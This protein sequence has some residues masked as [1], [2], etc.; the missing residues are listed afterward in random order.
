MHILMVTPQNFFW[1]NPL[2]SFM[3]HL[4]WSVYLWNQNI[5][6]QLQNLRCVWSNWY[7]WWFKLVKEFINAL[8]QYKTSPSNKLKS[9]VE[10]NAFTV[11]GMLKISGKIKYLSDVFIKSKPIIIDNE[12]DCICCYRFLTLCLHSDYMILIN[13]TSK[14]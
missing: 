4:C 12:D 11:S 14:R 2:E 9:I 8:I 5:Q 3:I 6:S 7:I 1:Q 13:N 10:K